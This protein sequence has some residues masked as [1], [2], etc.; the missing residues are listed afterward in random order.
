MDALDGC[1]VM[2]VYRQMDANGDGKISVE[3]WLDWMNSR[4][5]NIKMIV[6]EKVKTKIKKT[7]EIYFYSVGLG[8]FV[9][10]RDFQKLLKMAM[11]FFACIAGF[12]KM[13]PSASNEVKKDDFEAWSDKVNLRNISFSEMDKNR[14]GKIFLDEFAQYMSTEISKD[15]DLFDQFMQA[16][17]GKSLKNADY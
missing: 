14:S 16:S 2:E 5:E 7:L 12:S 6:N 10:E 17:H 9:K 3:E 4:M 15:S 1:D 13:H 11:I 8:G